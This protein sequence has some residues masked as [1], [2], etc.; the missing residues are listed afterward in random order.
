MKK[1]NT[2]ILSA[3]ILMGLS[4]SVNADLADGLN[5][6]CQYVIYGNG[7][8]DKAADAFL[9][10]VVSGLLYMVP[11]KERSTFV[12]NGSYN[13]IRDQA[14]KKAFAD[15]TTYDFRDKFTIGVEATVNISYIPNSN[16]IK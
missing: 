4:A 2:L 16:L 8:Y 5:R 11:D 10:G 12:A 9:L 6:Q 15:N 7:N 1:I 13:D 14:C 3:L